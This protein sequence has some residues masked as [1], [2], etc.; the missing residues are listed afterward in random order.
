MISCFIVKLSAKSLSESQQMGSA[1]GLGRRLGQVFAGG[2]RK[3]L[4]DCSWRMYISCF[5]CVGQNRAC[6]LFWAV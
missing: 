6:L 5:V 4:Q 1:L 3:L 2:Y